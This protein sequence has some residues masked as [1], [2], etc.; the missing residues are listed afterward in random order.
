MNKYII[1]CS[2]CIYVLGCN[3]SSKNIDIEKAEI[4]KLL[5]L[6]Q[7]AWNN[8]NIDS[9]MLGYFNDSTMQ[10]ITKNGVRK[11]WNATLQGYK[12]HYP[13][14]SAM[15]RLDFNI[16]TIEFLDATADI[17][18][19]NGKW[20]LFRTKDTPAGYFSLITKKTKQ[21]HRIIID[22]TW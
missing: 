10:F 2:F 18:H 7:N 16:D 4:A 6:Q 1:L 3:Y 13:D 15:G 20:R 17:G 8:G 22:H 19:I 21:G 14:K 11:G 12:K 9:F 5:S